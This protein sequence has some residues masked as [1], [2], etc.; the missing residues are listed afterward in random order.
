MMDEDAS[1]EPTGE[2]LTS[3]RIVPVR[4]EGNKVF[5][6][7][8]RQGEEDTGQV[9][10]IRAGDS[11]IFESGALVIDSRQIDAQSVKGPGGYAPVAKGIGDSN[12]REAIYG[13]AA[14]FWSLR[15]CFQ[16]TS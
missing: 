10:N 8:L 15:G 13:A 1:R 14:P 4:R 6:R 7:S 9:V 3:G 16:S 12:R 2:F 5:V 11:V